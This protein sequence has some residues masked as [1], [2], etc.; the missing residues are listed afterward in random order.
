M[1]YYSAFLEHTNGVTFPTEASEMATIGEK[2][3]PQVERPKV[4]P[5]SGKANQSCGYECE[6]VQPPPEA[7][8][9]DCSICLLV[10]REP[11]LISCCGH[12]FCRTCI[13][14]I[15][16]KGKSCPLCNATEISAMHNKGLERSLKEFEVRCTH[17]VSGCEWVGKLGLLD[18]H[19]N[20]NPDIEKQLEGCSFVEIACN[21][22]CGEVFSRRMLANHQGEECPKRPYSCDYCRE[23]A[24]TFEDVMNNHRPECKCYPLSCPNQCTPDAIKRQ[25][26]ADH[27][28]ND[29]PLM[30]V[31]CDFHYAGCEVQLSRKDMPAH[32]AENLVIHMSLLAT[33]SQNENVKL[34]EELAD[35]RQKLEVQHEEMDQQSQKI[36]EENVKLKEE[37]AD[38]HQ[39]LEVQHEEIDQQSQKIS[40]ENVKLKEELAHFRQKLEVQHEK[41]D[42]HRQQGRKDLGVVVGLIG[43]GVL[44]LAIVLSQIWN[45]TLRQEI[46]I[47]KQKQD[48][49]Q[50]R[51]VTTLHR[52]MTHIELVPLQ[53]T[54][55]DFER[56]KAANDAWYS[57][58][59]Y[60]HPIGYKMYLKVYANGYGWA[61]QTHIAVYVYLM[62]GMFDEHLKWPLLCNITI[63]LL[64]QK[65]NEG[66]RRRVIGFGDRRGDNAFRVTEGERAAG[67]FGSFYF[68]S[69]AELYSHRD[70]FINNGSISFQ[71]TKIELEE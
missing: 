54:M 14:R 68:I 52:V 23:Y 9:T 64:N 34:K 69:H 32:V 13:G 11:H 61:K 10:L 65:E 21:H 45:T 3:D 26:L 56:H 33:Q 47:L 5:A 58:P 30:V 20:L 37:L 59:F 19:L 22:R 55:P 62:Q 6:F 42:Q 24:S 67:G 44:V 38:F 18:N 28:S 35:F 60:T 66:H 51:Q 39:K 27:L 12:N 50:D 43:V 53:I 48:E 4:K 25:H 15:K 17:A 70:N 29:C 46:D 57:E 16:T 36:S 63:E 7:L 40:K 31:N 41:M 8:Q 2:G 71:I 1:E 49:A